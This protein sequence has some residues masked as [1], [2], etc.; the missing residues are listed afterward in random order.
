MRMPS[1][2]T[3]SVSSPTDETENCETGLSQME[4]AEDSDIKGVP[5]LVGS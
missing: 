5:F 1:E 4:I 2:T 3:A